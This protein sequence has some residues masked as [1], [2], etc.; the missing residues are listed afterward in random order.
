MRVETEFSN[1]KVLGLGPVDFAKSPLVSRTIITLIGVFLGAVKQVI[2]KPTL[3]ASVE[4]ADKAKEAWVEPY[5]KVWP[6]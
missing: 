2:G 6:T 1:F 3:V 5:R 4:H